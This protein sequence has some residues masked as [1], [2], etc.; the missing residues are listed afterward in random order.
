MFLVSDDYGDF[1]KIMT[2][3]ELKEMLIEEIEE[4]TKLNYTEYEIVECNVRQLGKIAKNDNIMTQNY[5]IDNLKSYGWHV[6]SLFDL[7]VALND[8]REYYARKHNNL[9]VF[10]DILDLLDKGVDKYE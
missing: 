8:L 2:F 6:Q 9:K 4:D 1:K 3:K 10:D 7:Q 5:V